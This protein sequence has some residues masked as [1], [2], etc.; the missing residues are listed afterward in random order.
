M[1]VLPLAALFAVT[2]LLYA[3]VGFGGGSVYNS[4]LVLSGFDYQLIPIV[5]LTCNLLVVAGGLVYFGR[6]GF[7]QPMVILPFLVTSVPA[8]YVGGAFEISERGFLTVLGASLSIS[9][10]LLLRPAP[11]QR[12]LALTSIQ[13]WTIGLPA[14]V[15]LGVLAGITGIGGGVFLAPLMYLS[16]WAPTRVISASASL[17][18]LVN[19][20]SGL[21]GHLG[22]FLSHHT[23]S[24]LT[25][26]ALLPLAVLAGGQVGSYIGSGPLGEQVIR[27]M[28]GLLVLVV[29]IRIL[30]RAVF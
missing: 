6:A 21:V 4:L 13:R 2:A 5:A 12:I 30:Y 18:I 14:G 16:G 1:G 7:L 29:G 8:A 28:T 17:F 20:V 9:G 11:K 22:K 26:Y 27:N 19:S 15:G 3:M 23:F 25:P 10:L 24:E